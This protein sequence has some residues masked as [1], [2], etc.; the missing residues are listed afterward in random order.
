M[1]ALLKIALSHEEP[2]F[3]AGL[4]LFSKY[5]K[6]YRLVGIGAANP[7]FTGI[8]IPG[9]PASQFQNSEVGPQAVK[10]SSTEIG[11]TAFKI[12][13]KNLPFRMAAARTY[14]VMRHFFYYDFHFFGLVVFNPASHREFPPCCI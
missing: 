5:F 7:G 9:M 1:K 4:L 13:F 14:F 10:G 6:N 3:S 11:R 12:H 8:F 2:G